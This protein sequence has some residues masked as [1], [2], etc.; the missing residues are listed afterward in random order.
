MKKI[1]TS[2]LILLMTL[3]T[4]LVFAVELPSMAA[5][6]FTASAGKTSM[7]VGE[8]TTLNVKANACGGKFTITSSD[9]SVVSISGDST[10]WIENRNSFSYTSCK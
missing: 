7:S 3:L 4:V 10:P 2:K 8:K 9:T 6:S 1:I 5:G